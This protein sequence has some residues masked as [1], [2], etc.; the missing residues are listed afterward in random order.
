[1]CQGDAPGPRK[2]GEV[3]CIR[4]HCNTTS[5]GPCPVTPS[6]PAPCSYLVVHAYH[7]ALPSNADTKKKHPGH[8]QVQT[9]KVAYLSLASFDSMLTAFRCS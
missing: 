1:M 8:T 5:R 6:S 3:Y 7:R 4:Q 9:G 2:F